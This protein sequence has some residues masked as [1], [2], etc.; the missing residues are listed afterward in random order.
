MRFANTDSTSVAAKR[1]AS[2][3][4][5]REVTWEPEDKKSS[6]QFSKFLSSCFR[7]LGCVST[8]GAAV[9]VPSAEAGHLRAL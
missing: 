4:T 1:V 3:W 2:A 9:A 8:R 6:S 7:Y 5:I